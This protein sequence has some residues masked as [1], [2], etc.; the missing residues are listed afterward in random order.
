MKELYTHYIITRFNIVQNWLVECNSRMR[1]S[2]IQTPEWLLERFRLFEKYCFPSVRNQT[3]KDFVW[4]V[5]FDDKTPKSFITR[6]FAYQKQFPSFTPLFLEQNSDEEIF[7]RKYIRFNTNT[8]YL[9]TTRLDS[10]DIINDKYV[11]WIQ[12][13]FKEQKDIIINYERGYQYD[14]I[15]KLLYS[16]L[17]DSNHFFSR[18]E[19]FDKN[20]LPQTV[21]GL[22]HTKL[23]ELPYSSY[24]EDN[25]LW[26]EVVHSCNVANSVIQ[27]SPI[28][29][30]SGGFGTMINIDIIQT[31][32]QYFLLLYKRLKNDD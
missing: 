9:I 4:L 31:A 26:I 2:T 8:E 28:W 30:P 7:V 6:I 25:P 15:H 5:L 21:I 16:Y 18:I 27:S 22:D 1:K 14:A 17:A 12:N 11:E 20:A 10:D 23:K 19:Y 13:H 29:K 32:V 3:C 24:R